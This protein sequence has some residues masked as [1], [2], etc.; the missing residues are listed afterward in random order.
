MGYNVLWPYE[1]Q[2]TLQRNTSAGVK[3]KPARNQHEAGSKQ[4]K[5]HDEKHRITTQ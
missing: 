5:L 4:R 3:S 2:V 1:S